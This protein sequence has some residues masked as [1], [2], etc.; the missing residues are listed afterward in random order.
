MILLGFVTV[1]PIGL[2]SLGMWPK[3]FP[4]TGSKP[5][6]KHWK[7]QNGSSANVVGEQR[8]F[9]LLKSWQ[10]YKKVWTQIFPLQLAEQKQERLNTPTSQ[11]NTWT[12][13][14]NFTEIYMW[15]CQVSDTWTNRWG[16]GIPELHDHAERHSAFNTS[17]KWIL[18]VFDFYDIFLVF[19]PLM[20]CLQVYW[21]QTLPPNSP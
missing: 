21:Y 6:R 18:L 15:L 17:S 1:H 13:V 7:L 12:P 3:D 14:Q 8:L 19:F 11:Q 16:I 10:W 4:K 9:H 20:W 5:I 2:E